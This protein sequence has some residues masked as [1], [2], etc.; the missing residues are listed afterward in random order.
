VPA[1][2]MAVERGT[3]NNREGGAA[4]YREMKTRGKKKDG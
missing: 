2:A 3:Q 1:D 4:R